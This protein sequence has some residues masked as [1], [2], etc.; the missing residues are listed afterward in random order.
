MQLSAMLVGSMIDPVLLGFALWVFFKRSSVPQAIIF[1]VI[2]AVIGFAIQA[3]MSS[4]FQASFAIQMAVIK[5]IAA[6]IVLCTL[7]F[8]RSNKKES[9]V[10]DEKSSE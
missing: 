7:A 4:T 3:T 1:A 8:F 6:S 2:I 5:F 10:D 9:A